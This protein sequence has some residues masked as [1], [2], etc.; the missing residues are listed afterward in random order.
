ALAEGAGEYPLLAGGLVDVFKGVPVGKTLRGDAMLAPI[1]ERNTMTG[2][3]PGQGKSSAARAEMAGAALDPTA[4]LRIWV[5]D[6]NFDFE[7]FRPRCSRYVMGAEDE[8][9]AEILEHLKELHAEV[10]ARGELLIKYEIP[11]VSRDYAF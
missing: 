9:I 3:M 6:A 1:M 8:K 7:A 10:Q 4:E 11:A 2:G 5:P